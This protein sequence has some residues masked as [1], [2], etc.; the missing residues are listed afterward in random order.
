MYTSQV[1]WGREGSWVVQI[2]R[3][4]K[5]EINHVALAVFGEFNKYLC[6]SA[7]VFPP[8]SSQDVHG[9]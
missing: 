9:E 1:M 5:K 7:L 2:H 8:P 3:G 4:L 6:P